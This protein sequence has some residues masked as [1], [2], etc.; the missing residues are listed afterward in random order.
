MNVF[1]D[2]LWQKERTEDRAY[3]ERCGYKLTQCHDTKKMSTDE[4]YHNTF[5]FL[6]DYKNAGFKFINFPDEAMTW[7]GE[8]HVFGCFG[9]SG[10]GYFLVDKDR[11]IYHVSGAYDSQHIHSDGFE[12]LDYFQAG[13]PDFIT[14]YQDEL[15][16]GLHITYVNDDLLEFCQCYARLLSVIYA[17][18]SHLVAMNRPLDMSDDENHC[19]SSDLL[20]FIKHKNPKAVHE[21]GFWFGLID[22]MDEWGIRLAP[23]FEP[24]MVSGRWGANL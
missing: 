3:F 24:Y 22:D 6:D 10:W 1:Y 19:L 9:R 5:M 16:H 14:K 21:E 20:E 11:Q 23:V 12:M 15:G 18:K 7:T 2:D 13:S 4:I 17:K 8:R